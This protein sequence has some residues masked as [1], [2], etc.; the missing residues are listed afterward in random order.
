VH[1]QL[2]AKPSLDENGSMIPCEAFARAN[3]QLGTQLGISLTPVT[4]IQV[5]I[6]FSPSP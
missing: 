6:F 1:S 4:L 2:S 3:A 5:G